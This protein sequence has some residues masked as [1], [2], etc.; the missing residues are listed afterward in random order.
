MSALAAIADSWSPVY[1]G[2]RVVAWVALPMDVDTLV[3]LAVVWSGAALGCTQS[4]PG[5]SAGAE[6]AAD[7]A[8]GLPIEC[9]VDLQELAELRGQVETLSAELACVTRER[10]ALELA[11]RPDRYATAQA[12]LEAHFARERELARRRE[13]A[14]L[15]AAFQSERERWLESDAAAAQE[16][17]RDA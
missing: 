12:E 13:Q 9:A 8:R 15:D 5:L 6:R 10:D 1:V 14:E 11:A 16:V 2:Q 3:D 4:A 17:R 7:D